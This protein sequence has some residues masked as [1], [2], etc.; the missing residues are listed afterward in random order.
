MK[1]KKIRVPIYGSK[2]I[3]IES[4]DYDEVVKYFK[5]ID[6]DFYLKSGE[7]FACVIVHHTVEKGEKYNCIYFIMDSGNK[8]N[9]FNHGVIAHEALHLANDIAEYKSHS[10]FSQEPLSY[11][12]EYF[13]QEICKFLNV[14]YK[15][16]RIR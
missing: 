3:F 4:K 10:N 13:V 14:K 12:V 9:D 6:Y 16:T 1:I 15:L 5:R 2:V 8:F 11:L 7:I